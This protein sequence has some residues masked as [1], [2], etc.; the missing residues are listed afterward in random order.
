MSE[1]ERN[2]PKSPIDSF[3]DGMESIVGGIEKSKEIADPLPS[4][5]NTIDAEFVEAKTTKLDLIWGCDKE[6]STYHIFEGFKTSSLCNRHFDPSQLG[7][8]RT[9]MD[10]GNYKCC[11]GCLRS[12][13][14]KYRNS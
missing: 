6:F 11:G 9:E 5:D 12:L 14:N 2:T 3:F 8:R 13:H 7:S 1:S 4:E 10:D